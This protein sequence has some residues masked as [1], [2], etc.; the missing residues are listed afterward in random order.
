MVFSKIMVPFDGSEQAQR[1]LDYA[2][3]LMELAPESKLYVMR[4]AAGGSAAREW[5]SSGGEIDGQAVSTMDFEEYRDAVERHLDGE[6]QKLVEQLGDSIAAVKDRAV[7]D[8]LAGETPA[9]A[10]ARFAEM[11]KIDLVV[12]GRRGLG[13]TRAMLGSVSTRVLHSCEC[14][15]LTVR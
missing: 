6:R 1:A 3:G 11:H 4:A 15:V 10:I 2:M 7:V 14:P 8:V 12:M 5:T 9:Q 13:A